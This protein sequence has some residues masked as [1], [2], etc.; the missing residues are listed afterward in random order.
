[1]IKDKI[2]PDKSLVKSKSGYNEE[3]LKENVD[4]LNIA[5]NRIIELKNNVFSK[6]DVKMKQDIIEKLFKFL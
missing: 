2:S 4:H 1:M 5:F 6:L 3:S